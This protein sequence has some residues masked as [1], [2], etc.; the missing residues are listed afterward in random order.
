MAD[1]KKV[2]SENNANKGIN[3]GLWI[4]GF[5]LPPLGY[6]F[7]SVWKKSRK[8]HRPRSPRRRSGSAIPPAGKSNRHPGAK[9]CIRD[10]SDGDLLRLRAGLLRQ[11][12]A[13]VPFPLRRTGQLLERQRSG[14]AGPGLMFSQP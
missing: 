1:D 2:L 8:S 13:G 12:P 3:W 5:V 14:G 9:M 11:R 7:Y 4:A 6:I 10:R